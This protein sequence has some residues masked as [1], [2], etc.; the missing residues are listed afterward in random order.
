M[1]TNLADIVIAKLDQEGHTS[2]YV[3]AS[4]PS[5]RPRSSGYRLLVAY[6]HVDE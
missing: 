6:V 3:L 2:L 1:S 4:H 5:S